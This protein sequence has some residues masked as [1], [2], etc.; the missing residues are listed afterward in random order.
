MEK[1]LNGDRFQAVK[2]RRRK[3]KDGE[4]ERE[5]ERGVDNYTDTQLV[6]LKGVTS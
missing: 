3:Y 1:Q 4:R 5:R 6:Q 2:E